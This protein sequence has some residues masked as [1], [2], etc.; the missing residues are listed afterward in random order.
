MNTHN[1]QEERDYVAIADHGLI[2]NLR[3][4]A[5]VSIDGSVESYCVPNFDSPSIFARILDKDKGGHFSITPTISFTTKQ[6]YLPSSNVLQTKCV[7]LP[8]P[9]Y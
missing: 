7:L 3:T 4:A 9:P 8:T 6:N 5:L 1:P 2:G